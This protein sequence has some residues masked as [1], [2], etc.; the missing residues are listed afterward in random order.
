MINEAIRPSLLYWINLY[1][2]IKKFQQE[3]NV[4]FIKKKDLENIN[5]ALL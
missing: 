1:S 3:Q 5:W 2:Y 4:S